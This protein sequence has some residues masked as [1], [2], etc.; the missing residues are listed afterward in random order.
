MTNLEEPAHLIHARNEIDQEI[1]GSQTDLP[2]KDTLASTSPRRCSTLLCSTPLH[3]RLMTDNSLS[4]YLDLESYE[5]RTARTA[6]AT[7][8]SAALSMGPPSISSTW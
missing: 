4:H 3:R 8:C 6:L 1:S 2:R 7:A 5:G